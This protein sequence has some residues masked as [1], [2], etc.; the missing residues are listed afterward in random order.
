M[1]HFAVIETIGNLQLYS[2][3]TITSTSSLTSALNT[4]NF[5][6]Y[7]LQIHAR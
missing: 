4:S 1:T 5:S 2:S 3:F 6:D 7:N